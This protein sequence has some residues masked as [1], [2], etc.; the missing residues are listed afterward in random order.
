MLQR[1]DITSPEFKIGASAAAAAVLIGLALAH[2]TL[3]DRLW[4][5]LLAAGLTAGFLA[6]GRDDLTR[7]HIALPAIWFGAVAISQ[8]KLLNYETEWSPAITPIVFGGPLLFAAASAV[9]SHRYVRPATRPDFD[10]LSLTRLGYCAISLLLLG[11]VG[12]YLKA[13]RGDGLPLLAEVID[14]ARSAGRVHVPAYITILTDCLIVSGWLSALRLAIK[15]RTKHPGQLLELG[16]I[17]LA[18]IGVGFNASRN[19]LLLA[20]FVPLAFAYLTGAFRHLTT[21]AVVAIVA[22]AGVILAVSSGLFFIRTSQ[23]RQSAFESY[24]YPSVV[25]ATSPPLRPLLPLYVGLATPLETLNRVTKDSSQTSVNLGIF[26]IPGIPLGLTPFGR[27]GDF[28]ALTGDLSRP[29]Y[30][31]VATYEGPLYADG[32][33]VLVFFMSL[34]LGLGFGVLRIVLLRRATVASLAL[35]AYLTYTAAFLF[36][37]N[38]LAFYTA[39]VAWDLVVLGLALR[40]CSVQ[41][42]PR[43]P[44]TGVNHRTLDGPTRVRVTVDA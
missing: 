8:L 37:E 9:V 12:T 15:R 40:Y 25:Q 10:S 16:M 33:T 20:L 27:R 2:S 3:T 36:Y 38:A 31:N 41:R 11:A 18:L 23:H 35:A 5:A 28:Y 29:Y 1:Y 26:S 44:A 6:V 30:F 34:M 43:R 13:T 7:P 17:L 24:F 22:L 21:R 32:G 19:T 42:Q 39:S 4:I 14:K